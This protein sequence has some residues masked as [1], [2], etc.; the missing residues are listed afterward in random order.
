M[1]GDETKVKELPISAR[2]LTHSDLA[3]NVDS[4]KIELLISQFIVR[5]II[6][7]YIFQ[8]ILDHRV[9]RILQ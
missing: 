1:T 5:I 4:S 2:Y 6:F 9:P 8:E 7:K 3:P